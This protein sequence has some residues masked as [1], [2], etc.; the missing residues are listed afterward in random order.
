MKSG[1][2]NVKENL[3]HVADPGKRFRLAG[4]E[5][6]GG[7]VDAGDEGGAPVGARPRPAPTG[8]EIAGNFASTGIGSSRLFKINLAMLTT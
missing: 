4:A 2:S 7:T 1:P 3:H 5:Q 6:R 8:L